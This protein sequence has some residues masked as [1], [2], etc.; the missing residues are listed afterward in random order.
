MKCVSV[1]ETGSH[2]GLRVHT[3]SQ[4]SRSK[5][6]EFVRT[7]AS[8]N[9]LVVK[10]IISAR[11]QCLIV[12]DKTSHRVKVR[13]Y[14]RRSQGKSEASRGLFLDTVFFPADVIAKRSYCRFIPRSDASEFITRVVDAE[15]NKVLLSGIH[16]H[17][18]LILVIVF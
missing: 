11:Y 5:F 8:L 16:G 6:T 2:I 17:H 9:D 15:F 10:N 14:R 3:Y 4:N 1:N 18:L 12:I 13:F 7:Q